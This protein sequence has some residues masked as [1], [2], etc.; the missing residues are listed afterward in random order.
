ARAPGAMASMG[1][2][3]L[4]PRRQPALHRRVRLG[5]GRGPRRAFHR[6]RARGPHARRH[7]RA[8]GVRAPAPLVRARLLAAQRSHGARAHDRGGAGRARLRVP[9]DGRA[10]NPRR[11]VD[12]EPEIAPR[13]L[14]PRL[15]LRGH[16]A[17]GRILQPPLARPR[18]LRS[19]F[20]RPAAVL[21][22]RAQAV[23]FARFPRAAVPSAKLRIVLKARSGALRDGL[24][25]LGRPR[26]AAQPLGPP[27]ENLSVIAMVPAPVTPTEARGLLKAVATLT[28]LLVGAAGIVGYVFAND[29]RNDVTYV[30]HRIAAMAEAD[31]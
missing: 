22:N 6:A 5:L 20:H 13:D 16:P 29:V 2:V 1:A 21:K 14:A 10:Q 11:G 27:L 28:A 31:A 7:R 25:L 23:F 26:Y 12:R 17:P 9:P 4:R 15:P 8:R 19:A 18:R 30:R 3:Q 24:P